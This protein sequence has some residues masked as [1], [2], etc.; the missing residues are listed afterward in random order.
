MGVG[1][2]GRVREKG[3]AKEHMRYL[4]VINMS[5]IL[6]VMFYDVHTHVKFIDL[7]IDFVYLFIYLGYFSDP[8]TMLW[9]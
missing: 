2:M 1:R 4:W 3:I 5:V 7:F 8:V 9:S 6:I